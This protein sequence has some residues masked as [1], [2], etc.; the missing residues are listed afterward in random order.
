MR[1]ITASIALLLVFAAAVSAQW[2]KTLDNSI[3]RTRDGKP[4]LSAKTPQARDG[5]PDLSGV[6]QSD[7]D[8]TA[9]PKGI[10]TVESITETFAIPRYFLDVTADVK[11][12]EVALQPAATAAFL[13]NLQSEGKNDPVAHCKPT[14]V[15]AINN[16]PIPF[17]IV[18]TDKLILILYEDSSVFRQ[19]FLDARKT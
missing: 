5:K 11:P 18:Q 9:L 12:P 15:P 2:A 8:P 10:Q 3:P 14:G 17:K 13:Q 4:D 6:W 7:L 16:L 1:L 19:V